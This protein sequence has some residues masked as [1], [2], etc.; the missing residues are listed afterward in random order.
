MARKGRTELLTNET[1]QGRTKSASHA[2]FFIDSRTADDWIQQ[3]NDAQHH[4]EAQGSYFELPW[5]MSEGIL[6]H[7][8]RQHQ[9]FD[10]EAF[11][12]ENK[13]QAVP[14]VDTTGSSSTFPG[15]PRA[16]ALLVEA[17]GKLV[18]KRR[19]SVSPNKV[20][21]EYSKFLVSFFLRVAIFLFQRLA[22]PVP[23]LRPAPRFALRH[24]SSSVL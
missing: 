3:R 18:G 15:T 13:Q 10:S 2:E 16:G 20:L 23:F 14:T 8:E 22:L 5:P 6:E 21:F 17:Y 1:N 9:N 7:N 19:N 11:R 4:G 24:S 12:G